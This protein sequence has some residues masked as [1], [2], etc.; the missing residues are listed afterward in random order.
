MGRNTSSEFYTIEITLTNSPILIFPDPNWDYVLYTDASKHILAGV[1]NQEKVI[2]V[3]GKDTTL[4]L[5]ITYISITLVG[6]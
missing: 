5:P 1:L 3:N 4:L 6:S 2:Q